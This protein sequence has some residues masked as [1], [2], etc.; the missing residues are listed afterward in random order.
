MGL[1]I[2][3]YRNADDR[4]CTL[5]GISSRFKTL[6]IVNISGPFVPGPHAA[7]ALLMSG[8]LPGTLKIV[9]AVPDEVG[10][11]KPLSGTMMGGNYGA[12]SDSRF[13]EACESILGRRFYGAV[14]IHDRVE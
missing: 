12:C 11:W 4:D 8:N 5:N 6:C 9:P 7:P 14:A 10:G 2:S 1:N 3:V 13:S